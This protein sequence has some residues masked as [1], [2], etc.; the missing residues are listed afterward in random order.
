MKNVLKYDNSDRLCDMQT[1]PIAFGFLRYKERETDH[2]LLRPRFAVR[3]MAPGAIR[4]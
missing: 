1:M 2:A 4:S 3:S